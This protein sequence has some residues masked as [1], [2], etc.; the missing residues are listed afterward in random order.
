MTSIVRRFTI[1][2]S[3]RR[4]C[5][6][7][8]RKKAVRT[9]TA[10]TQ[11]RFSEKIEIELSRQRLVG[12]SCVRVA[13][14]II[15][16]I[17]GTE[18]RDIPAEGGRTGEDGLSGISNG[19]KGQAGWPPLALFKALL[20]SMWYDLSDVK[21]AEALDDCASFRWFCGFPRSEATLE[22]TAFVRFRKALL[23]RGPGECLS[24]RGRCRDV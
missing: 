1:G 8:G 16:V 9:Y 23:E 12:K 22:R 10:R 6:S 2:A 5:C 4:C 24:K 20:L 11:R 13:R 15:V 7:P 14:P 19:S 18:E 17:P 21:L 3:K